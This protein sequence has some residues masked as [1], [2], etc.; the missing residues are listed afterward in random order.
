MINRS[1]LTIVAALLVGGLALFMAGPPAYAYTPPPGLPPTFNPVTPQELEYAKQIFDAM[2]NPDAA[3]A[4]KSKEIVRR[5]F[6][7]TMPRLAPKVITKGGLAT[8]AAGTWAIVGLELYF[9]PCWECSAQTLTVQPETKLASNAMTSFW[10][11]PQT[12]G[13]A[14]INSGSTLVVT[15]YGAK[16]DTSNQVYAWVYGVVNV[17][18]VRVTTNT[19]GTTYSTGIIP[20]IGFQGLTLNTTYV[21][22]SPFGNSVSGSTLPARSYTGKESV[23][24]TGWP[25]SAAYVR[26]TG[27]FMSQ[28]SNEPTNKLLQVCSGG[29]AASGTCVGDVDAPTIE[30]DEMPYGGSATDPLAAT[31][32]EGSSFINSVVADPEAPEVLPD[33]D[34]PLQEP[35]PDW[36]PNTDPF[37]PLF[38]PFEDPEGDPDDDGI[39]NKDDPDPEGDEDPDEDGN[40]NEHP[41]IA[42]W[43]ETDDPEEDGDPDGD[44]DPDETDPAIQPDP[45]DPANDPDG[46]PDDDGIPNEDDPDPA[47]PTD[48]TTLPDDHPYADPDEDGD[49]NHT[50]PDDDNDG[51]PDEDDPAPTAPTDPGSLPSTHPYADPDEDGTP[52]HTDP[53]DDGD[54]V[55]DTEDPAPHNP[56]EPTDAPNADPDEDGEPNVTDPD[57]DGDEVPDTIDPEP[58]TPESPG[59]WSTQD[60]DEDGAPDPYDPS[61]SDPAEPADGA[62]G[63]PDSDG[64]PNRHDPYPNNPAR[65][66]GEPSEDL[67][68]DGTPNHYDPDP[69]RD[70]EPTG[71]PGADA[72]GDGTPNSSDPAPNDEAVPPPTETAGCPV[73]PDPTFDVPE[74]PLDDIFP[75]NLII[76]VWGAL[77]Q[78]E[79]TP[80]APAFDT[81]VGYVDVGPT[82]DPFIGMIRAGIGLFAICGMLLWFYRYI[83]GKGSDAS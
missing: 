8:A 10:Q 66:S 64:V 12:R 60:A 36:D 69:Y 59:R 56:T 35:D 53:D 29:T 75:F 68:E 19:S 2:T 79:G 6:V 7:R 1:V 77:G 44:G 4:A 40:P 62:D 30:F 33:E 28:P 38:D 23:G 83:T 52:N 57:D 15:S 73:A 70:A 17:E 37:S 81:P 58:N 55:P 24:P 14:T 9:L 3:K 11:D 76:W 41:P 80:Q 18:K 21:A 5:N 45:Y 49:P 32:A 82:F 63:D 50:D 65:P 51:I 43:P 72:D 78:L 71:G 74:I 42:P 34:Q 39:P 47:T 31:P 16:K 67:D 54:G 46:D 27:M 26:V 13:S 61:P 20:D 22:A 48:P 25:S